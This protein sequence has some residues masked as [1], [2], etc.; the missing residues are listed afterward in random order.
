MS[1]GEPPLA[2][3]RLPDTASQTLLRACAPATAGAAAITASPRL[4]VAANRFPLAILDPPES[5]VTCPLR[6]ILPSA[7]R[8]VKW[9]GFPE[10]GPPCRPPGRLSGKR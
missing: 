10:K 3:G 8:Q 1:A 7:Y 6:P 9:S 2:A 4:S 5:S